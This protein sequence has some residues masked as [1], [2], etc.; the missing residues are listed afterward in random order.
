LVANQPITFKP[1]SLSLSLSLALALSL[2]ENPRFKTENDQLYSETK[3]LLFMVLKE[4]PNLLVERNTSDNVRELLR[5]ADEAA[6]KS[7]NT[8][9]LETLE[10]IR[11]N[12]Q[13][14][15]QEGILSEADDFEQ[16]RKDAFEVGLHALLLLLL[17]VR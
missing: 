10:S 15:T 8:T 4:L 11:T 12:C 9:L 7:N 17:A 14:L 5:L 13:Y 1:R 3:Y 16:L 2:D 6:R